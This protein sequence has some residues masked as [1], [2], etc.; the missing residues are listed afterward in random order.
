M[1][2]PKPKTLSCLCPA[3]G[4]ETTRMTCP[5]CGHMAAAMLPLAAGKPHSPKLQQC[6]Q[7]MRNG[8]KPWEAA[9]A[10]GIATQTALNAFLRYI[11]YPE[12]RE[13]R[14]D[15]DHYLALDVAVQPK[16]AQHAA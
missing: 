11:V 5:S 14:I 6:V 8:N 4:H 12:W 13:Q 9:K 7:L 2:P 15:E 10:V 16:P 3:C 1:T